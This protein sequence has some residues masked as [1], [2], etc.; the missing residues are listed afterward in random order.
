MVWFIVALLMTPG[1]DVPLFSTGGPF[2]TERECRL[3]LA[4]GNKTIAD[5]PALAMIDAKCVFLG[6]TPA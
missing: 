2:A 5:N 1:A 4:L 6:G 3:A